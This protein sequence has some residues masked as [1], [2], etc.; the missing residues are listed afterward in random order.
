M[1]C[2]NVF[3]DFVCSLLDIIEVIWRLDILPTYLKEAVN[4]LYSSI[5]QNLLYWRELPAE[6]CNVDG[7]SDLFDFY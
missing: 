5:C 4:V 2:L 1:I 6:L 3:T 7:R